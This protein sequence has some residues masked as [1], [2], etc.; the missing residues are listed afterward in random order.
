MKNLKKITALTLSAILAATALCGCGKDKTANGDVKEFST[1]IFASYA[2]Y[3]PDMLMFKAAEEATGV[4]LINTVSTVSSDGNV[5][6]TTM[7]TKKEL[8]DVIRHNTKDLRELG[9]KG[10]LIPLEDLIEEHAP[11]IKAFFEKRPDAK[12][13]A[14][15]NGHIYFI[16]GTLNDPEDEEVAQMGFFIRQDW[17]DKL[18]LKRPTTIQELH[19]VLYAFATQ[20][21]NGNGLKDE[22]P[23]FDRA[24]S[25]RGLLPLYC[26]YHEGF[27]NSKG[28]YEYGPVTENYKTAMKELSKWYKEGII[29]KEYAT[30]T[31][32]RE[33]LLGQNIGGCC[34]DWFSST[35]KFNE[36]LAES[37][38]GLNFVGMLTPKDIEGNVKCTWTG[39]G[40]HGWGWGISKDADKDDLVDLIK[41]FDWWMSE[42]GSMIHSYGVEGESYTKD[43]DGNIVWG[44]EALNHTDGI[45]NYLR[46]IGGFEKGAHG[47]TEQS[48][49]TM[50]DIGKEAF[51]LNQEV[52]VPAMPTLFYTDE[53]QDIINK[54]LTN[55]TTAVEEQTQ[56][57]IYG[58]EDVD[59]TWDKYIKTLNSMGVQ[60]V[61]KVQKAAFD[62]VK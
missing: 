50:N 34:V 62:R 7:L 21:P 3:S 24:K 56:K 51:W 37:V 22:V 1:F 39:N 36:T 10:G 49:L 53:E 35:A 60:E 17:L 42:E 14:T 41:Y 28:E 54:Y 29:D 57:W 16:P 31:S 52:A 47:N 4:R 26:T 58:T 45:P 27:V 6:Y 12:G 30:R 9:T 33:Q 46:T 15:V 59:A 44:E 25:L 23:F 18:G 20:D 43:A 2:P 5:A 11:N 55:V 48:L 38:P 40:I 13:L 8:P 61:I 19:D 32:V